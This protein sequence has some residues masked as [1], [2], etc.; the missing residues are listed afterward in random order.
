MSRIPSFHILASLILVTV[1][2]A[3]AAAASDTSTKSEPG[4]QLGA[5]SPAA[6]VGRLRQATATGD[7]LGAL[8]CLPP[9]TRREAVKGL[10][11]GIAMML[12]IQAIPLV[13][14]GTEGTA[15]EGEESPEADPTAEELK[16]M[17]ARFNEIGTRYGL[18]ALVGEIGEK[19]GDV[20]EDALEAAIADADAL[21]LTGDLFTLFES[22][23]GEKVPP[24][25]I[26]SPLPEG[27]LTDLEVDGDR[28]TG[29]IGDR[30][31]EFVRIDGRWFAKPDSS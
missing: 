28:A 8:A 29:M 2:G 1:L 16:R 20:D 25:V 4:I 27:K 31:V 19:F 22:L 12:R 6:V 13:A 15:E 14:A 30:A 9:D 11:G 18:P 3:Y 7:L 10:H 24:G 17:M 26:E 21:A 23:V 5:D